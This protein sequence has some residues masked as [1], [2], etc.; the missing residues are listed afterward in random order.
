MRCSG[1]PGA[2]S[3]FAPAWSIGRFSAKRSSPC[4]PWRSR[5]YVRDRQAR[6]LKRRRHT[7]TR[8][9]FGSDN[10]RPDIWN[11]RLPPIATSFS[12]MAANSNR[13]RACSGMQRCRAPVPTNA[14]TSNRGKISKPRFIH[15]KCPL[16]SPVVPSQKTR[17]TMTTRNGRCACVPHPIFT[18][19]A[20]TA[21]G[22]SPLRCSRRAG[23][24]CRAGSRS[25]AW[26]C[27]PPWWRLRPS[28]PLPAFPGST[29]SCPHTG[30]HG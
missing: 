7:R 18:L 20:P 24:A 19:R 12:L 16:T 15:C 23:A 13:M 3:P 17:M 14:T 28:V 30:R 11:D 22:P 26:G 10:D 5:R 21:P 1:W 2:S 8:P 25:P 6:V 9:W 4:H 27:T 29:R